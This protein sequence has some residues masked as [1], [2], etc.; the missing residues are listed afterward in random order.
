MQLIKE[1]LFFIVTLLMV[2]SGWAVHED[3]PLEPENGLGYLLGIVGGSLMLALLVYPLRKRVRAMSQWLSVR[4]WFR[5]HM[6]F[7]VLGPVII[8]F[9]S[10]F[11]LGSTNSSIALICM[12]LVASSG[13]VGRY[14]YIRIHHGLYGAKTVMS[15]FKLMADKRRRAIARLLPEA[16]M[17]LGKLEQLE[18]IGT[19]EARSLWHALH[20][21]RIVKKEARDLIR[22]TEDVM[23][24]KKQEHE[25]SEKLIT[26]MRDNLD[27]YLNAMQK[28]SAFRINERLFALW[29]IFHLPLFIMMLLSG[30]VHVFVVHMY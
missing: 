20:L 19:I 27:Q 12:L 16:K 3:Y 24:E 30:V 11:G 13:L 9:H 28:A 22:K 29:H 4:F 2:L 6:I 18:K 26:V 1:N 14:L 25:K 8:L 5:L 10:N 7:G 15:E 23:Q 17:V 21:K